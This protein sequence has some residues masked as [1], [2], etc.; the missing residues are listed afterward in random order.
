M[1]KIFITIYNERRQQAYIIKTEQAAKTT[2]PAQYLQKK[3]NCYFLL[4][5]FSRMRSA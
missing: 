5:S 3:I 1:L 4:S 2:R